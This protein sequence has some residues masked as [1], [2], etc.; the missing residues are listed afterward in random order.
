MYICSFDLKHNPHYTNTTLTTV[1]VF[2]CFFSALCYHDSSL[3][4]LYLS[5]FFAAQFIFFLLFVSML[6]I[7]C[8]KFAVASGGMSF[9]KKLLYICF[10]LYHQRSKEHYRKMRLRTKIHNSA[11]Y[12]TSREILLSC[13]ITTPLTLIIFPYSKGSK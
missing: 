9:T 11:G 10:N 4:L 13:Y 5:S 6:L 3:C 8:P 12:Q 7:E 1:W 2:V